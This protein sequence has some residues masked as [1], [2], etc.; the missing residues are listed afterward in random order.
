VNKV[1]TI[2][3]VH[4]RETLSQ[5]LRESLGYH[6]TDVSYQPSQ[7]DIPGKPSEAIQSVCLL[8]DY[9]KA[10]QTYLLETTS[11]TRTTIRSILEPFYRHHPAGDYL[12]I[13]TKDYSQLAFVRPLRVLR[14]G[15]PMPA[16][17]LRI[18]PT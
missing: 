15:K 9:D 8:S 2:K 5:Y 12:F 10:F 11:L 16:L 14:P 6:V 1:D 17:Q 7:L 13:F 18:L 4:S 3:K